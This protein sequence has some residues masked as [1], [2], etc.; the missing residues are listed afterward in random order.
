[1]NPIRLGL[2]WI[3]ACTAAVATASREV[4]EPAADELDRENTPI[5]A[6]P[7]AGSQAGEWHSDLGIDLPPELGASFKWDPWHP[8]PQGLGAWIPPEAAFHLPPGE[9]FLQEDGG[10]IRVGRVLFDEPEGPPPT[11]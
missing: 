1:M 3:L 8:T 10:T 4:L 5:D 7:R 2:A 6:H 11:T 9:S